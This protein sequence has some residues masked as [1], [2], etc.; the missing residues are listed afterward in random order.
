MARFSGPHPLALKVCARTGCSALVKKQTAKYCSVQCSSLD[1]DR[2]ARLRARARSGQVLPLARQLRLD[3]ESEE[4][5]LALLDN[6][7]EEIP[8]GLS[9]WA[10]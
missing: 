5:G 6:L 7:R 9:R 1:P 10:V 4:L 3:F 8:I 2:R